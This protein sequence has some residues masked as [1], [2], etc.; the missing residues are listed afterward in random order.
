MSDR[1]A[2]FF[3]LLVLF[4]CVPYH[5]FAADFSV[6]PLIIDLKAKP[7]DILK[8]TVGVMNSS[9]HVGNIYA[10]VNNTDPVLGMQEWQSTSSAH[11]S[12]SLANW[13]EIKRGTLAI[14]PNEK[15]ELP[16]LIQVNLH[17]KPGLYHATV[18]FAEGGTRADAEK[19]IQEGVSIAI[20]L[21]VEDDAKEVMELSKFVSNGTFISGKDAMFS[22]DLKNIGNRPLSPKGEVRIFNKN[23]AEVATIPVN[24]KEE[25]LDPNA[26]SQLASVWKSGSRF[27]KYK[28]MLNIEYGAGSRGTL[29][30]TV[31]FWLIPWKG[32]LTIFTCLLLIFLSFVTYWHNDFSLRKRRSL[33]YAIPHD[34]RADAPAVQNQVIPPVRRTMP[35]VPPQQNYFAPEQE[36]ERRTPSVRTI[37]R[38]E[39]PEA[40]LRIQPKKQ[41]T[42]DLRNEHHYTI[43]LKK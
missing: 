24:E 35:A 25:I 21:E 11:A 8:N 39:T 17:A 22:Y 20:N 10:F 16:L 33:A 43:N 1:I 27:G 2:M 29:Q 6:T 28:A 9:N 14:P 4:A 3:V 34:F 19:R 38:T 30:D 5:V 41:D 32:I 23:G 12:D 18:T 15:I 40:T 7:R 26:S 31:F 13:I 42:I 36:P 37:T